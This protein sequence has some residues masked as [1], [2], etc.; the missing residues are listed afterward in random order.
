MYRSG[1]DYQF[2]AATRP[3][4]K[5]SSLYYS[6]RRSSINDLIERFEVPKNQYRQ[7]K[8]LRQ[9][10]GNDDNGVRQY[11]VVEEEKQQRLEVEEC[12]S[13]E[14]IFDKPQSRTQRALLPIW[15]FI[16]PVLETVCITPL[17]LFFSI[18]GTGIFAL[19]AIF[20]LPRT[21]SQVLLYPGFRLL[22]GTLYP[23]YASYKAVKTKNVKE[24]VSSL[25]AIAIF[26][27]FL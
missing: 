2:V 24:Y 17:P 1:S 10:S 3:Q 8:Y 4:T 19:I 7:V 25:V 18:T 9:M 13:E 26:L 12:E 5:S 22:F 15:L 16:R 14:E 11:F 21:L 20:I 23:A 6:Q 27:Y